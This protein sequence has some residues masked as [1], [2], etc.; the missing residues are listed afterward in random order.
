MTEKIEVCPLCAN[1]HSHLF[2]RREFRG[3]EVVN[4]VC[5][6]CG[7]VYQS[8][9]MT[10]SESDNFYAQ[11]YRSLYEGSSQPTARNMADQRGR[12]ESLFLFSQ[13]SISKIKQHLDIGCSVG[14][15]LHHFQEMYHCH[16]VGIE[17]GKE[18]RLQAQKNGLVVFA[19][20]DEMQKCSQDRFDLISMVHVLEHLPD[21]LNY[22]AQLREQLLD[23]EGW[24]LIEVPNLFA[25]DS[26]EIAHLVSYSPHTVKQVLEKSGF[27]VVKS[28]QHGRPRSRILPLYISLLARPASISQ[29]SFTLQPEKWVSTRRQAGM[30][31]RRLLEHVFPRQAW[32]S[33]QE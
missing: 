6:K 13:P 8:P 15:L 19:K 10:E 20:L 28:E 17:P 23:P 4:R 12:A 18:H 3:H 5:L 16:S 27:E 11:E 33:S 14:V 2:D 1:E 21:P 22:I 24:L 26:F 31:R 7:L 25:H 32:I 9:R 29:R 30:L